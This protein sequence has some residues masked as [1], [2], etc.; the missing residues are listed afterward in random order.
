M[1]AL[2]ATTNR[3]KEEKLRWLLENLPLETRTLNEQALSQTENPQEVGSSH[4]ENARL[5]AKIWSQVGG[6]LALASDGGLVIPALEQRWDS[7]L[8]HRF[9][10]EQA[11]DRG[12]ASQLL[13]LMR[14]YR[15]E[16]RRA[17]WVEALAI[18]DKGQILA[19]WQVE[20][21]LGT[22]SESL[23][24]NT[25]TLDRG[26]WVFDIWYFPQLSKTYNQLTQEEL[27]KIQDHWTHL[28]ALVEG[29]FQ[30]RYFH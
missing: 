25:E 28:K 13:Q 19:S 3:A 5:K 15:G 1:E 10:G 18:A 22:L 12:R 29:F 11:S 26:F 17:W 21:P 24:G 4:E 27:A 7:L 8:T 30:H 9:A 2:L 20:G 6:M 16:E 23:P 14:P